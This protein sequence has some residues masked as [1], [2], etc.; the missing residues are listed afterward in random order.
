MLNQLLNFARV[1]LANMLSE[2]ISRPSLG[3]LAKVVG[4]KLVALP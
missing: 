1:L 4:G 3:I 2:G